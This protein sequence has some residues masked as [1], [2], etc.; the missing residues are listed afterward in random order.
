MQ[1]GS[2]LLLFYC[3]LV[4]GLCAGNTALGQADSSSAQ[5]AVVLEGG[6]LG[7]YWSINY[8][9][10]FFEKNR[11]RL[12]GSIGISVVHVS[13]FEGKFDPSFSVPVV[14]GML[15]GGPRH[16]LELGLSNTFISTVTSDREF[17]AR[18]EMIHNGAMQIGYRYSNRARGMFYKINY[19][20]VLVD[21]TYFVNWA[22]VG[23]GYAF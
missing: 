20:A 3:I 19:A 22:G 18:R 21:Y 14:A 6:G 16:K 12:F 1:F 8:E 4:A 7:G 9:R 15:Y 5:Q 11:I 10:A 17:E 2:R 13:N 23:M